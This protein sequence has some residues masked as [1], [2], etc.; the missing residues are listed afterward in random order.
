MTDTRRS[1][2]TGVAATGLGLSVANT[3]TA[4]ETQRYLVTGAEGNVGR[5]LEREGFVV[6][7]ALEDANVFVVTG[8]AGETDAIRG[9]SGVQA[10]TVDYV[11]DYEEPADGATSVES[12]DVTGQQ[13]DKELIDAF[14]A[15]DHAT[16]AD[17]R[18][19][20][21]DTG[22]DYAHPDL[23]PNLNTD[24][25]RMYLDG[26]VG[27]DGDDVHLHG[28][29]V[30]GIAAGSGDNGLYGVAPEAELV[31]LRIYGPD[32]SQSNTSDVFRALDYA[33]EIGADAVN[34]SIGRG[35]RPPQDNAHASRDAYRVAQERVI[36]SVVRRG[37]SVVVAAGNEDT[38]LQ[39]GGKFHQ[40]SSLTGT[41]G[42][43]ATT[44]DDERASFS[45]YGTNTIDVGAPG[46]NVYS[47]I[48]LDYE[49]EPPY[50]FLSGTS[51]ASPQVAGLACLVRE[52]EPESNPEQVERAIKRGAELADGDSHP[53]FG[54]GRIN[55][56]Q[57]AESI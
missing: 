39:H 5:R 21:I 22:I 4:R 3:A 23:A 54:A 17:T 1:F 33:A 57:T 40:W 41:L 13:W 2:L 53:D 38:N 18:L 36:R 19:A 9:V 49:F 35:P 14:E 46:A 20:V 8:P 31:S 56:L 7:A 11:I 44:E 12:D 32:V 10:A 24:L 55:A 50:A 51:M 28:T 29:H 47:A 34:M 48:P 43:S 37:T 30:A 45:N 27:E 26:E 6:D 42:V 16:G 25:S 52:L 15:H